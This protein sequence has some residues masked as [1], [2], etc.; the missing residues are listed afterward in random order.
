VTNPPAERRDVVALL[1]NVHTESR[2]VLAV[3]EGLASSSATEC[4]TEAARTVTEFIDTRL[5]LHWEDEERSIAPRLLGRHRV[6]DAALAQMQRDH[7]A[8]DAPFSRLRV[9]CRL[10]GADIS[11][12]HA[13]RFELQGAVRDARSRLEVHHALEESIVFPALRR[14]LP[15]HELEAIGDEI[16]AR[17]QA[18]AA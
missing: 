8:L 2:H 11:R 18:L 6:V 15:R 17:R 1:V 10:L 4:C 5:P 16:V 12:L 14:L 3:A 7:L 13:L 9:L